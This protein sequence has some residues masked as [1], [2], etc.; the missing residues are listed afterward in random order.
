MSTRVRPFRRDVVA[1]ALISSLAACG[2]SSTE[3]LAVPQMDPAYK[4]PRVTVDMPEKGA[5]LPMNVHVTVPSGGHEL[6]VDELLVDGDKAIAHLT[7]TTPG[8][9]EMTTQALEELRATIAPKGGTAP[10]EVAVQMRWLQRGAQYFVAPP[11]DPVL[12]VALP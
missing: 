1:A 10:R 5:L 11:Y 9:D 2:A 12:R 6:A 7:V 3:Y 4:G 8:A